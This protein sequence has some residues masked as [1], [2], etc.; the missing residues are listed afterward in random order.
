MGLMKEPNT[1]INI[2]FYVFLVFMV[3]FLL[4]LLYLRYKVYQIQ[5][6]T[7]RDAQVSMIPYFIRL[8]ERTGNNQESSS[9]N[10]RSSNLNNSPNLQNDGDLPPKYE[11]IN[12]T[13]G[14]GPNN[15]SATIGGGISENESLPPPPKYSEVTNA[16]YDNNEKFRY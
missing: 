3:V 14:V 6:Q 11:D 2:F 9:Q 16:G 15:Y 1:M 8:S 5:V 4:R 13:V 7:Q 12:T 10:I